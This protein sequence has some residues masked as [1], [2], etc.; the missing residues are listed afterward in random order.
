MLS[1]KKVVTILVLF[2]YFT[3]STGFYV[4]VHYCMNR[5]ASVKAG[6]ADDDVCELCGMKLNGHCCRDDVKLF[7]L[8]LEHPVVQQLVPDF[9]WV[10]LSAPRVQLLPSANLQL[11]SNF[12][13][14]V[15]SPPPEGP[16][17][18]VRNRVFRI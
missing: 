4:S 17:L 15:V 16:P 1:L 14:P 9:S 5:V 6:V 11:Q 7:K 18:F 13:D 3:V 2:V 10:Y 8:K 12:D